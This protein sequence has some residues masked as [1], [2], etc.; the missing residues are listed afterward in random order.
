M[1]TYQRASEAA[2]EISRALCHRSRYFAQVVLRRV[3]D[4]LDIGL[5]VADSCGNTDIGKVSD[6]VATRRALVDSLAA[7]REIAQSA[8]RAAGF[9]P[10]DTCGSPFTVTSKP[11]ATNKPDDRRHY[12][13]PW[14]NGHSVCD[15]HERSDDGATCNLSIVTCGEC[16]RDHAL[17]LGVM[18]SEVMGRLIELG[19]HGNQQ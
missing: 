7:V 15:G 6:T 3:C 4:S 14:N 1:T 12:Q 2:G 5:H 10:D 16:L 11:V 8:M 19:E 9:E 17:A 18:R 13:P